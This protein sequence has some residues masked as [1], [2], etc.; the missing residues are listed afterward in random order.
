MGRPS[1]TDTEVPRGESR[2]LRRLEVR[3]VPGYA[4]TL[5]A[6][7]PVYSWVSYC[8]F[9]APQHGVV[10][11][12]AGAQHDSDSSGLASR[13]GAKSLPYTVLSPN[14]WKVSQEMPLGSDTQPLLP[15]A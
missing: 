15:R 14:V 6:D 4:I 13:R 3:D 8:V 12:F 2:W 10:E 9:E 5:G 1:P 11:D 7:S